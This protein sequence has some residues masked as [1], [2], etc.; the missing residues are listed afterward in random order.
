MEMFQK[1]RIEK[2]LLN[3]I[4]KEDS[5]GLFRR[6]GL[7]ILRGRVNYIK[8]GDYMYEDFNIPAIPTREIIS[9]DEL[10]IP[11]KEIKAKRTRCIRC[12]YFS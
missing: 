7:W 1:I 11:W 9:Y 2:G 12:I 8:N 3:F 5:F 6:N 4:P 10:Y